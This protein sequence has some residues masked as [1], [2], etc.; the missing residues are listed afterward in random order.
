[1]G[2][3]ACETLSRPKKRDTLLHGSSQNL[4]AV[5]L[6][7]LVRPIRLTHLLP[8]PGWTISVS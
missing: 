8:G 6:Q 4:R 7:D 1:M 3:A 5:T 2:K